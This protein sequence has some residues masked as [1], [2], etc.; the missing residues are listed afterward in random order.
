VPQRKISTQR[1][2]GRKETQGLVE[3]RVWRQ[4]SICCG[5][6]QAPLLEEFHSDI[7]A[8]QGQLLCAAQNAII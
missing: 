1:R 4:L 7:D 3:V 5:A 8:G 6:W 2:K